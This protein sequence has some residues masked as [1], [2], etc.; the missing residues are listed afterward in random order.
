MKFLYLPDMVL[1]DLETLGLNSSRGSQSLESKHRFRLWGH[2]TD[3]RQ[4]AVDQKSIKA[5]TDTTHRSYSDDYTLA[6]LHTLPPDELENV[7]NKFLVQQA[8]RILGAGVR[9]ICLDF[10]DIHYHGCPHAEA[11]E[12]CHTTP[13]W[14]LSVPLLPRWIRALSIETAHRRSHARP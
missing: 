10:A 2:L 13:R 9:L 4:A 7:G 14:Y 1:S 5:V 3:A 11:G 8:M 12:L 6:Q